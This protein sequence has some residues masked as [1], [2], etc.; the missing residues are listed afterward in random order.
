MDRIECR[1]QSKSNTKEICHALRYDSWESNIK[2][3]FAESFST[4][5]E[6]GFILKII[7]HWTQRAR[8]LLE[9]LI[10][11]SPLMFKEQLSLDCSANDAK[12]LSDSVSYLVTTMTN[13]MRR[14]SQPIKWKRLTGL[15]TFF[16][17]L[18]LKKCTKSQ[19]NP[20]WCEIN[21]GSQTKSSVD[22]N[23]KTPT[24]TATTVHAAYLSWIMLNNVQW[25]YERE[26]HDNLKRKK[27]ISISTENVVNFCQKKHLFMKP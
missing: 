24:A 27:S 26:S 5:S 2:T 10:S 20:K 16:R 6:N 12:T 14:C 4:D 8:I 1:S 13:L 3:L 15:R 11:L 23:K 7:T 9:N 17:H 22:I 19:E 25:T 21:L 18:M